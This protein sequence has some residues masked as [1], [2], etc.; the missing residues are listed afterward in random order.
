MTESH[1]KSISW[2]DV[3]RIERAAL[4]LLIL[5]G[6]EEEDRPEIPNQKFVRVSLRMLWTELA[7]LARR[8][9]G[10]Q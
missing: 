2:D 4:P 5:A 9:G 7:E 8:T 1:R 3:H 6:G 10:G